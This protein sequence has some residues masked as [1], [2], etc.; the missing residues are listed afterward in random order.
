MSQVGNSVGG[1]PYFPVP[2]IVSPP[3]ADLETGKGNPPPDVTGPYLTTTSTDEEI[4]Q[5]IEFHRRS[6]GHPRVSE[7]AFRELRERLLREHLEG[8]A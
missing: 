2:P 7:K 3:S 6:D 1:E 8:K 4:A 5:Y